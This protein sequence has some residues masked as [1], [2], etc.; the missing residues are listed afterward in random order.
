MQHASGACVEIGQ[1]HIAQLGYGAKGSWLAQSR[2]KKAF[3]NSPNN[4]DE[5]DADDDS[6]NAPQPPFNVESCHS[7][8]VLEVR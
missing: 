6:E 1:L 8:I 5:D 7:G 2:L 3:R 4:C